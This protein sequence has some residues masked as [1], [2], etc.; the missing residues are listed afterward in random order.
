MVHPNSL[1]NEESTTTEAAPTAAAFVDTI[2]ERMAQQDA[3]QK[4]KNEQP[5]AIAGCECY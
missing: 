3:V 2:M 1:S 5:A 4:V